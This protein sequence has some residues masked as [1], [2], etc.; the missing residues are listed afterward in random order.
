MVV[1]IPRLLLVAF[2]AFT[3]LGSV[4]A[5]DDPTVGETKL[6]SPPSSVFYFDDSD[7]VIVQDS[8]PGIVYRSTDA[9]ATFHKA[10]G[11]NEGEPLLINA[12]PHNNKVA[13][14][15]GAKKT[16]WITKDQG[17]TWSPFTIEHMPQLNAAVISYHATDPDK[18][19]FHVDSCN[20]FDCSTQVSLHEIVACDGQRADSF[21]RPYTQPMVSSRTSCYAIRSSPAIGQN[22]QIA[23]PL[24]MTT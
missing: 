8:R 3:S 5:K 1:H 2:L 9:G 12:H 11:I 18:I 13:I 10:K 19:I 22:P 16:H 14:V 7:V 20:G 21:L 24:A 6:A 17:E 4:A 15:I 23:S